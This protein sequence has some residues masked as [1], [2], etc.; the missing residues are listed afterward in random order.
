MA[1][2]RPFRS[3]ETGDAAPEDDTQADAPWPAAPEWLP[4][5]P[6]SDEPRPE[7]SSRVREA[8]PDRH[9]VSIRREH[10]WRLRS[11]PWPGRIAAVAALL[12]AA[13]ALLLLAWELP[14]REPRA[15]AD[16]GPP[17]RTTTSG[18]DPAPP[19]PSSPST[20]RLP[21][22]V[23]LH[24]DAARAKLTDAGFDVRVRER[25]SRKAEGTV[26]AQDPAAGEARLGEPVT[27]SVSSGAQSVSVPDVVGEQLADAIESLRTAGLRVEQR[28]TASAEPSGTVV[29]QEPRGGADATRDDTIVVV[30]SSGPAKLVVPRLVGMTAAA[31]KAKLRELGLR[32]T[33]REA[34]SSREPAGAVL[35]QTPTTGAQVRE[36]GSVELKVSTGAPLAEVPDVTGLGVDEARRMLSSAGFE[37]TVEDE[38]TSN[39]DEDATVLRQ[40]PTAGASREKGSVVSIVVGRLEG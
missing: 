16:S 39:P 29:R 32:W 17:S 30:V 18:G 36:G 7:E 33:V 28:R 34:P 13:L 24:V 8:R 2:Q 23:G 1:V 31:A 27:L 19:A 38:P 26:L 25:E 5:E 37:V 11:R 35:Q 10:R 6:P 20:R 21:L 4:D 3:R 14:S 22:V 9:P 40:S 12:G 15:G